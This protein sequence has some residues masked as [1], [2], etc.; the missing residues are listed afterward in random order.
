MK[1]HMVYVIWEWGWGMNS[2]F[3][4]RRARGRGDSHG[5]TSG[6]KEW[7]KWIQNERAHQPLAYAG[8]LGVLSIHCEFSGSVLLC[9]HC[10]ELVLVGEQLSRNLLSTFQE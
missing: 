8:C 2:H 4:V 5:V 7:R 10:K 1:K 6:E 3:R 9:W